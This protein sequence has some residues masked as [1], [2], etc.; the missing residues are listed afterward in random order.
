MKEA[1]RWYGPDDPVTLSDIRQAGATDIVTALHEI[2]NGEIWS[3]ETIQKR[4]ELIQ[5]NGLQWT[6]V[7][8]IPVHEDIKL[9]S[10]NYKDYIVNYQQSIQNLA[11]CG[12]HVI[13]YNFMPVLDWTRTTL[14][15]TLSDGS[16]ALAFEVDAINAFDLFIVKREGAAKT[17]S[18]EAYASAERYFNEM[19][20]DAKA[21]LIK[22]VIAGLPGAEEGY[23]LDLF[24]S[25]LLKY[26]TMDAAI[27]KDN[28]ICFLRE[29][30][31]VAEQCNSFLSIHPDDPPF[32]LFGIPRVVST[33]SDLEQLFKA[34]PSLHNGL[35]FCTGS[36]GVRNSNNLERIFNTHAH[37]IHFL[38]L[39]ST[40]SDTHG[41]FYEADHL[42]GDVDMH[43]IV[44]AVLLEEKRRKNTK[45]EQTQIPMRP[46]HGHQMLDDLNKKSNPGYSAI[47]RLRGLAE[48]RG[49]ALGIVKSDP[50]LKT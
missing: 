49:L 13:C 43:A 6:V 27:L 36:L 25:K 41:N 8:S 12:I 31:P 2:P 39:R 20:D 26:E 46:D 16:K 47:G 29:L 9:R 35:T 10:G 17:I 32:S 34:V 22:S 15:K 48:L 28:L 38:H 24:R 4:K 14:D 11:V 7:E 23:D 5:A 18:R 42:T 44:R 50:T 19:N 40:Q 45:I 33:S 3:V 21:A 1:F 37:R 30:V